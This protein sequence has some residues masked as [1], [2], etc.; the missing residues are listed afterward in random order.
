MSHGTGQKKKQVR[1]PR[2]N[3]GH[4]PRKIKQKKLA[5]SLTVH[6]LA[7]RTG[8]GV[9]SHSEGLTCSLYG[10]GLY[11]FRRDSCVRAKW[12]REVARVCTSA[13]SVA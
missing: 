4:S 10:V 7:E 11:M 12:P 2:K 1:S 13:R 5:P 3:Q 6:I 8:Y 9:L